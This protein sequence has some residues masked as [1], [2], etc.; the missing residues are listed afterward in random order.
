[1]DTTRL[2]MRAKAY[3]NRG[4]KLAQTRRKTN[5]SK[6]RAVN[7]V[8]SSSLFSV[9]PRGFSTFL[10]CCFKILVAIIFI[11]EQGEIAYPTKEHSV[12]EKHAQFRWT[13]CNID[14]SGW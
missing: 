2:V 3:T 13:K 12:Q 14:Y 9:S 7:S 1:M 6:Y 5:S 4:V 11:E 8:I 10:L